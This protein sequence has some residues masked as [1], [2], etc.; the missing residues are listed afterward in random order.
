MRA[1]RC[2]PKFSADRPMNYD[3]GT[4]ADDLWVPAKSAYTLANLL[5]NADMD[6]L[7]LRDKIENLETQNE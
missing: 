5:L 1:L 2:H 4:L 3:C 6:K 7:A